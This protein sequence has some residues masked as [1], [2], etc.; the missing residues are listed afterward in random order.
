[1]SNKMMTAVAGLIVGLAFMAGTMQGCGGSDGPDV[2]AFCDK[3]CAKAM[4]CGFPVDQATCKAD[5]MSENGTCT[6]QAAIIDA[7]NKCFAMAN[8]DA[9]IACG[10]TTVPD[11]QGGGGGA[12]SG[13]D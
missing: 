3:F 5:C 4:E 12:D 7:S 2:A 6:N 9:V 13:A 11:C 10:T 8:C 1:M